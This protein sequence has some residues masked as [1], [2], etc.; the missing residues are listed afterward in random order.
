M[1]TLFAM[2]A[3]AVAPDMTGSLDPRHYDEQKWAVAAGDWQVSG[4]A[5]YG[6]LDIEVYDSNGKLIARDDEEDNSPVVHL[7]ASRRTTMTIRVINASYD[8]DL[9]YNAYLE[10]E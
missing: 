3:A 1:A 2:S 5:N 7:V 10:K 6:D 4:F 8:E 9:D